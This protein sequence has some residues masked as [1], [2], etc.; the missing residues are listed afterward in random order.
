MKVAVVGCRGFGRV[1]LNALKELG[2]EVYVFSREKDYA[3][4]CAEEF[5][6][7]QYFT[8]FEEVIKSDADVIDL[9]VS[10]E[11]HCFMAIRSM[12]AGKNVMVEKPI[13]INMNEARSMIN[14]S[15]K[16]GV[17][18]MVLENH[19]LDPMVWEIK[20]NM[21]KLGRISLINVRNLRLNRP[22]GWRRHKELMG[23]GA[24]IDG[25]IHYI[26]SLLNLGG[27]YRE[28]KASCKKFFSG[29]EGEDTVTAVF[30]FKQGMIGNFTYSWSTPSWNLPHFEVYGENGNIMDE[31]DEVV[32]KILGEDERRFKIEKVNTVKEE[33][34]LFLDSIRKDKEPP[35]PL[36]IAIRDL[37]CV[38]DIYTSCGE[39]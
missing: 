39:N 24:L 23:G 17:K 9:V 38:L 29:L 36:D 25:G 31:G 14:A 3:K 35:I 5:N 10:H 19:Y 16:Y 11:S 28:V 1:H 32:L 26:D 37:K 8:S 34:R 30:L 2:E 20:K 22:E 33:I 4:E 15:S 7:S 12:T 21:N 13:A 18:F 6:A 27:E